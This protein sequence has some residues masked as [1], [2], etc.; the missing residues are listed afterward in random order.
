LRKHHD[1]T[2]PLPPMRISMCIWRLFGP[3]GRGE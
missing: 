1:S 2:G 3:N